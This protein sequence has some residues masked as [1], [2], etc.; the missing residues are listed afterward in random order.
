MAAIHTGRYTAD[1]DQ[2]VVVFLIGM[3][4]NRLWKVWAWL[5]VLLAMVPMLWRL[6]RDPSRGLLASRPWLGWRQVMLVQH[7]E[8]FEKLEAFARSPDEPHADAWARFNQR[9]S[10]SGDTG[11][12]HE[13]YLVEPGTAECVYGDMPEMGLPAAT[14][15]VPATGTRLTARQRLRGSDPEEAPLQPTVKV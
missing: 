5:P 8:S 9:S 7:W 3:R 10:G 15:H 12:W 4:I 14:G 13:T 6:Q 11:I 2:P 1:L